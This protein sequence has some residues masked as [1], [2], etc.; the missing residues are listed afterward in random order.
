MTVPISH[1]WQ[2][3]AYCARRDVVKRFPCKVASIFTLL[4]AGCGAPEPRLVR[5]KHTIVR[6]PKEHSVERVVT[7]DDGGAWAYVAATPDGGCQIVRSGQRLPAHARCGDRIF[8]FSRGPGRLWYDARDLE[9][10][11]RLFVDG[12]SLAMEPA[13]SDA[14]VSSLR[15]ARWGGIGRA[16]GE[17]AGNEKS[18]AVLVVA[19]GRVVGRYADATPPVFSPD[20]T[21]SAFVS[22]DTSGT[23]DLV[24]DGIAIGV[25][26]S[27]VAPCGPLLPLDNPP[28]LGRQLQLRYLSDGRLLRLTPDHAGW[29]V[30]R[31]A[32]VVASYPTVVTP[33]AAGER[34]AACDQHLGVLAGSLTSASKAPVAA[35]WERI[36]GP[37]TDPSR[38]RPVRDAQEISPLRCHQPTAP[39]D[40]ALSDDGQHLGFPCTTAVTGPV[41]EVFAVLD[42]QR[43]GPYR[44]VWGITVSPDGQHLAY[45][46]ASVGT[47]DPWR[48]YRD[49][50]PLSSRYRSVWPPKFSPDSRHVAWE[51]LIDR[52]GRGGIGIDA[53]QVSHFDGILS[54]PL[55]PATARAAWVILRG[56]RVVR[57]DLGLR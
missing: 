21:H 17:P 30:H 22:R 33:A 32:E 52:N 27:G 1:A 31:D 11:A 24:V 45:G 13:D 3:I 37:V 51:A 46:A 41:A 4:A 38:W 23:M 6:L 40:L 18:A 8:A 7:S 39:S 5:Q 48:I 53:M 15:G 56:Q 10:H 29:S 19:D 9:G 44:Q 26:P 12:E 35:W 42:D 49:G 50:V 25:I 28:S 16:T 34:P 2:K 14:L 55:F 54:G 20:E 57:L 43:F 47:A 36:E